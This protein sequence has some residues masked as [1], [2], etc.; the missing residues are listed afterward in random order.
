[1][2]WT[3]VSVVDWSVWWTIVSVVDCGQCG[4]LWSVWWTECGQVCMCVNSG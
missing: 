4:G 1:M 3:V 2:W